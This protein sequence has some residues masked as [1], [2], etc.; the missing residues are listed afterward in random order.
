M[1]CLAALRELRASGDTAAAPTVM[2]TWERQ[3]VWHIVPCAVAT[4]TGTSQGAESGFERECKISGRNRLQSGENNSVKFQVGSQ[5]MH[6]EIRF[7]L[8]NPEARSEV[9][10]GPGTAQLSF[11]DLGPKRVGMG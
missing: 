11:I 5:H 2:S 4:W 7:R 9:L 10:S 3:M 6:K 1:S 8:R